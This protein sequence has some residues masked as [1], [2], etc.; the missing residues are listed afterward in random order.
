MLLMITGGFDFRPND[1]HVCNH[2]S[3][4]DHA[5]CPGEPPRLVTCL[6]DVVSYVV[7]NEFPG[8]HEPTPEAAGPLAVQARA[9]GHG[10]AQVSI[11][12]RTE[13]QVQQGRL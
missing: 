3:Q 8:P 9:G 4:P 6:P 7:M 13:S 12:A 11:W 2:F 5:G 1:T 10:A